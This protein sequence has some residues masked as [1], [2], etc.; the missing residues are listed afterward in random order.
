MA[1]RGHAILEWYVF[2][3]WIHVSEAGNCHDLQ[4]STPLVVMR[5]LLEAPKTARKMEHGGIAGQHIGRHLD[6]VESRPLVAPVI[7]HEWIFPQHGHRVFQ[8][9]SSCDVRQQ[10]Q[11]Q[12]TPAVSYRGTLPSSTPRKAHRQCLPGRESRGTDRWR[13]RAEPCISAP[14]VARP[15]CTTEIDPARSFPSDRH[16]GYTRAALRSSRW[17]RIRHGLPDLR[18]S[19]LPVSIPSSVGTGA[20]SNLP[21][22]PLRVP[23]AA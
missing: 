9:F 22:I 6:L 1:G 20:R 15:Q 17:R 12:W 3:A 5:Q 8:P 23:R 2:G 19:W 21:E 16:S 7:V 11:E 10:Q 18:P 13:P 4:R 14:E